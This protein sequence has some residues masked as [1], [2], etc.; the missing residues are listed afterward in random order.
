[1]RQ[2]LA[3]LAL[4]QVANRMVDQL[5][6]SEYR[7]LVIG[8]QLIKDPREC[9]LMPVTPVYLCLPVYVCA[10]VPVGL[11]VVVCVCVT[12]LFCLFS[13]FS[14]STFIFYLSLCV[15]L[16]VCLSLSPLYLSTSLFT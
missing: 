6:P 3:D 16:F 10:Y 8:V 5:T 2:V 7:R 11:V 4:T 15:C 12:V 14:F 13:A 1:M 9:Y